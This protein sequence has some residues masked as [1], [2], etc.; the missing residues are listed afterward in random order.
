MMDVGMANGLI[1]LGTVIILAEG[2]ADVS[3]DL[4]GSR[5]RWAALADQGDGCNVSLSIKI[6]GKSVARPQQFA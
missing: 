2:L 1:L 4:H 3:R 5:H 6:A